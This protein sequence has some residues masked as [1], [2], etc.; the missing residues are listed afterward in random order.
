M[1]E[2]VSL[3][4]QGILDEVNFHL[5]MVADELA[6]VRAEEQADILFH[7]T[8]LMSFDNGY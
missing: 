2:L 6:E 4:Y 8:Y 5:Q 3:F 7:E 1:N